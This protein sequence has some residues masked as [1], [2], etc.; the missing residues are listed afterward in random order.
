MHLILLACS[1]PD[2]SP[3]MLN[4]HGRGQWNTTCLSR[5]LRNTH[6]RGGS[7]EG[8]EGRGG[9][10]GGRRREGEGWRQNGGGGDAMKMFRVPDSAETSAAGTHRPDRTRGTIEELRYSRQ[11]CMQ[12]RAIMRERCRRTT[13]CRGSMLIVELID[14]SRMTFK[15]KHK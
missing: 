14:R 7:N 1:L 2:G 4:R 15:Q 3:P 13:N 10:R 6:E 8:K 11:Y 5:H 9:G 12:P